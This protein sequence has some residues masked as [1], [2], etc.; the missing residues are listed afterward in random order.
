MFLGVMWLIEGITKI[1]NGWLKPGNIFIIAVDGTAAASGEAAADATAAA[2]G[3]VV[4]AGDRGGG[5]GRRPR[6]R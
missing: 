3:E 6:C 4:E 5:P 2:S 1:V